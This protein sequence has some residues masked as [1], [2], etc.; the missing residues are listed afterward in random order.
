MN[1][2]NYKVL[3]KTIAAALCT[4]EPPCGPCVDA[5]LRVVAHRKTV[6]TA[7]VAFAKAEAD[8][9]PSTAVDGSPE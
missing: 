5:A 9:A 4:S 2:V 8:R 3:T 7:L 6:R 1:G